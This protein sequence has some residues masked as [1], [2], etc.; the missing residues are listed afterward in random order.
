MDA[1]ISDRARAA[2]YPVIV[3]LGPLLASVPPTQEDYGIGTLADR[4]AALRARAARLRGAIVD[5]T[6][7]A[8]MQAALARHGG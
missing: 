6:T 1:R 3:P 7:R 8:R 5:P 4:A 2:E